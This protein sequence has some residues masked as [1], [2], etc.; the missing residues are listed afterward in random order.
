VARLGGAVEEFAPDSLRSR[1][2]SQGCSLHTPLPYSWIEIDPSTGKPIQRSEIHEEW[3]LVDQDC[4][5]AWKAVIGSGFL[6]EVRPVLRDRVVDDWGI[7][8]NRFRLDKSGAYISSDTP[9][10]SL[11]PAVVDAAF[12][13]T[14]PTPRHAR[15]LKTWLGNRYDRPAVPEPFV[16]LAR[17]I[18]DKIQAKRNRPRGERVRDILVRFAIRE[19]GSVEYDLVAVTLDSDPSLLATIE[20]WLTEV[21]LEVPTSHGFPG[22]VTALSDDGVSLKYVEGSYSLDVAKVS[23][24]QSVPGPV[25]AVAGA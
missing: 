13:L 12:H 5:L 6:A 24:P 25:G 3:V 23:W 7:R 22:R 20:E 9:N 15:R 11:T 17:L 2:W 1:G 21:A 18:A 19:D 8:S 16:G 4:D 14:C 10:T